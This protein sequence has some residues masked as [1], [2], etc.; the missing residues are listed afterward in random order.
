VSVSSVNTL[1]SNMQSMRIVDDFVVIPKP[2]AI[3][4]EDFEEVTVPDVDKILQDA[5]GQI[6]S[7]S[8]AKQEKLAEYGKEL[9]SLNLSNCSLNDNSAVAKLVEFFPNL[10]KLCVSNCNLAAKCYD[11]LVKF[12]LLEELNISVARSNMSGSAKKLGQLKNLKVLDLSDHGYL[13][14]AE[15]IAM[16]SSLE[17]LETLILTN[18]RNLTRGILTA[19][20]ALKQLKKLDL[21]GTAVVMSLATDLALLTKVDITHD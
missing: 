21:R 8:T 18:C 16:I 7:L 20:A 17:K 15:L 6:T 11:Q 12:T 14:D 4:E 2:P 1:A 10:L 5:L 9:L 3:D 13:E 19:I